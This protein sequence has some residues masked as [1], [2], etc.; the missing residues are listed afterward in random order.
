MARIQTGLVKP[1][2]HPDCVVHGQADEPAKQQVVLGLL[3]QQ[4]FRA[5][6]VKDLQK[7]GAQQL[8]GR[9]ARTTTFDIGGVHACE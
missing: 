9:N 3:H 6:A 5:D 8:L 2:R 1:A 7:H 4:T